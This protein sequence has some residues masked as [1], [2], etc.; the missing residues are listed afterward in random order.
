MPFTDAH[1]RLSAVLMADV[2]FGEESDFFLPRGTQVSVNPYTHVAV[3]QCGGE[4]LSFQ[5]QA[6]EY[7]FEC[8]DL[9]ILL[10]VSL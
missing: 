9:P 1:L 2:A 10:D 4:E 7:G 8:M 5:L 6:S 3:A